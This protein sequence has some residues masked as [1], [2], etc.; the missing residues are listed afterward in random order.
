MLYYFCYFLEEE[1]CISKTI[2]WCR[3]IYAKWSLF[4][5]WVFLGFV[6]IWGFL[7]FFFLERMK[8]YKKCRVSVVVGN[9]R[10][11]SASRP[12]QLHSSGY[13]IPVGRVGNRFV[14]FRFWIF[15]VW[16]ILNRTLCFFRNCHVFRREWVWLP[17]RLEFTQEAT[18]CFTWN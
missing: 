5:F 17:L 10:P 4:Y 18:I 16:N 14:Q 3:D 1:D 7:F 15:L 6:V 13:S 12:W 2:F 8:V 11:F 9:P